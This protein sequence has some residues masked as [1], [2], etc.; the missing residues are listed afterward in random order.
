M[1]YYS[2][3]VPVLAATD[4]VSYEIAVAGCHFNCPNCQNPHLQSFDAGVDFDDKVIIS[5]LTDIK[6]Y[7]DKEMIDNIDIIGGEPL[8]QD[9]EK[10][11]HFLH[12]LKK[13][14]PK[15]RIWI[16][17]GYESFDIPDDILHLCDYIKCGRYMENLRGTGDGFKSRFGPYLITSNQYIINCEEELK[18]RGD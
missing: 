8:D 13:N 7:Y 1:R 6:H 2:K 12:L 3:E 16:Y 4:G 17:T 11:K 15:L 5:L 10:F 9:R 18:R 14:F